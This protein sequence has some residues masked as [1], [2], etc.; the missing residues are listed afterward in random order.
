MKSFRLRPQMILKKPII[1]CGVSGK[2]FQRPDI[3]PF[4]T[5]PGMG[6]YLS[7]GLKAF[8]ANRSGNGHIA[9]STK[10]KPNS[11]I[12]EQWWLNSGCTLIRTNNY[13][14]FQARQ[15]TPHKEWKITEEDWRNREKWDLYKQ[16]VDEM[17][18][19][20]S[21]TYAPWTVVEANS[22]YYARIKALRLLLQR[23]RTNYENPYILSDMPRLS[24]KGRESMTLSV[25]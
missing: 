16:A 10:W 17:L 20:T 24:L 22:K 12:S 3:S 14:G 2:S 1:I 5:E 15:Q 6:E 18:F 4:L 23:L 13:G 25:H 8:A 21:T 9:R 7:N 11:Q 19:R